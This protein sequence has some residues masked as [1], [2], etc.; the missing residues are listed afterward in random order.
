MLTDSFVDI[1][2]RDGV[3]FELAR[4][5]GSSIENEAWN[6]QASQCH[7]AA[8]NRLVA[9]DQNNQCIEEIPSCNELDGIGDDFTANQRRPHAFRPHGDA[10]GNTDSVELQRSSTGGANA[11]LHML[12]EFTEVIV[13]GTDLDPGIG[14]ANQ[15]FLEVFIAK[16]RGAKH[17]ARTRAVCAVS[18]SVTARLKK[19]VAHC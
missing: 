8:G 17:R 13:A 7:N 3:T 15:R 11:F 6:I 16:S 1:L 4:S 5:Y 19:S 12:R 9:A 2:Y 14:H 10:I 18:Q